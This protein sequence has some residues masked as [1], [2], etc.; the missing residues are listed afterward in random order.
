MT[1]SADAGPLLDAVTVKL[2]A[3][4]GE[5]DEAPGAIAIAASATAGTAA[6]AS[7]ATLLPGFGS[8]TPSGVVTTAVLA[9]V[10]TVA[11]LTVPV[12]VYVATAPL[13]R[14][15]VV[16]IAFPAPAAAPQLPVPVVTAHVQVT[17]AS[18]AGT[19]SATV[20]PT[21]GLGPLFVTRTVHVS[22]LPAT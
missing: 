9:S 5:T 21:T 8:R 17:P 6:L 15:T 16:E 12:I 18:A 20:A 22:G 1:P 14:L 10:P 7:V 2:S 13:A 11:G 4:L 3:A 19:V